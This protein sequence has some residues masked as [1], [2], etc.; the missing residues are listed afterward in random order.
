MKY[1]PKPPFRDIG[2]IRK[3]IE[4]LVGAVME[5]N[6][7]T[8][9]N[10][11]STLTFPF[12]SSRPKRCSKCGEDVDWSDWSEIYGRKIKVCPACNKSDFEL[13]DMFC[14]VCPERMQLKVLEVEK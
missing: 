3:D 2:T 12:R 13:D 5:I 11:D 4:K 14:D 8:C 10:C 1:K 6:V 9:G 7:Y